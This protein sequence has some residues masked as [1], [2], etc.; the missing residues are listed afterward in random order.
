MNRKYDYSTPSYNY[1]QPVDYTNG[2]VFYNPV[3]GKYYVA[4]GSEYYNE[5]T[6]LTALMNIDNW[7][8]C[9]NTNLLLQFQ[10][11]VPLLSPQ[12]T[13]EFQSYS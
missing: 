4:F 6:G 5:V 7:R 11:S 3:N 10:L 1:S 13:L 8:G 9:P 2:Q 12:Q